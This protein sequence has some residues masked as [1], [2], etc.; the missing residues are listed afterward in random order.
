MEMLLSGGTHSS[1]VYQC[2]PLVDILDL[3]KFCFGSNGGQ[4]VWLCAAAIKE[5]EYRILQYRDRESF[6]KVQEGSYR[7]LSSRLQCKPCSSP[8][9]CFCRAA[10]EKPPP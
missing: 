6:M 10:W 7:A 5:K 4:Y 2:F 1:A 3:G 9:R 8:C